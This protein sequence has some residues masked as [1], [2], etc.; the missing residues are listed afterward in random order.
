MD[1]FSKSIMCVIYIFLV[2]ERMILFDIF[3]L[4]LK[5]EKRGEKCESQ[6]IVEIDRLI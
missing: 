6:K 2:A 1:E 3:K 4:Q 5:K